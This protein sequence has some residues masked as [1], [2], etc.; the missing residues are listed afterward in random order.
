[1]NDTDLIVWMKSSVPPNFRKLHRTIDIDLQKGDVVNVTI[2]NGFPVDDV[3]AK[4]SFVLATTTWAGGK[5]T[6]LAWVYMAD[7]QNWR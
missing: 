7:G 3:N 6:F 5:N 2:Y 4:K 1:M